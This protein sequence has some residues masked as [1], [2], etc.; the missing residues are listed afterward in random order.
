[1]SVGLDSGSFEIW[2]PRK[3]GWTAPAGRYRI[4]A[5]TASRNLPLHETIEVH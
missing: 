1:M 4:L 5:G 2:S 3:N